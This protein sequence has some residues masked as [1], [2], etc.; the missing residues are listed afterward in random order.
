[1]PPQSSREPDLTGL[2]PMSEDFAIEPPDVHLDDT[3][4]K[5]RRSISKTKQ[6]KEWVAYANQRKELYRQY[7]P[8]YN[9]ALKK[10]D[11]N[12]VIA[13]CIIMEIDGLINFI[14]GDNGKPP[15]N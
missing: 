1:M 14:E 4:E 2:R 11:D 3:D 7:I 15:K 9:P 13:E 8:G 5:K 12:W 10:S 6:W